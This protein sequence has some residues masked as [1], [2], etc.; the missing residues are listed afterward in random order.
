MKTKLRR[1]V[2]IL[3]AMVLMVFCAV[4]AF[5]DDTVTKNDLSSVKWSIVSKSSDIPHFTD[6]YNHFLSTI[7]KTDN[8][9][10]VYGK[11]SDGTSET[12]ILYFDPTAI[13]Y[14][15]FTN[16]QFLFGSNYE[17]DSQRLLFQFDSSDNKTESVGYGGWDVA[18]PSGFPKSECRAL[19]NL[20]DYVQSTVNVYFHIKIYDFDNLENELEPPDPNAAPIP[21]T[22]DYSPSL[23]TGLVRKGTLVAPGAS[24]DGQ[25]VETNSIAVTVKMTDEFINASKPISGAYTYSY[26]F[27]CFVVPSEYKDSDIK[28]MSEHSIYTAAQDDLHYLYYENET[29]DVDDSL[30]SEPATGPDMVPVSE[31][32]A[33]ATGISN[34]FLL[35]RDNNTPLRNVTIDLHNIDFE[36]HKSDSYNIVVLG[37]IVRKSE[38]GWTAYPS[39]FKSDCSSLALES[40]KEYP[41]NFGSTE[42]PVINKNFYDY[43]SVI[44]EDWSF[45]DYPKFEPH[46][47]GGVTVGDSPLDF[48]RTAKGV[49]DYNMWEQGGTDNTLKPD[50]FDKYK[51]Q[52]KLDENFGSFD[53]G[54]DSIKSVFDGSSDF[55]KFLTA[56]I[57]ILPTTFLT[58]LISFFAVMLAI[59]VAKWVLK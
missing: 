1:F 14:Y 5:A 42:Q 47:V 38:Y 25:E 46:K 27:T 2:S 10:A 59:C 51:E 26:Q 44:S 6:V 8:Y 17:Y 41:M 53:F 54:L 45:K 30:S 40:T 11:K 31:Q 43:F 49:Q 18:K 7:S 3:S 13:A 36:K 20:N 15:S 9:I 55:F 32:W 28:T 33:N 21:F 52:K 58:I 4:P 22:V 35:E 23:K 48:K 29:L 39:F 57:G 16:N 56:S 19:L 50:D 34:C 24:N 12:N 37:H